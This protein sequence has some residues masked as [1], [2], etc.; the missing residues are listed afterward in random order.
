[1]ENINTTIRKRGAVTGIYLGLAL[2]ILDLLLYLF[3]TKGTESF[4]MIAIVSNMA[5]L[6]LEIAV[7]VFFCN[8]L[9]TKIGGYWSLRQ[10]VTG[11]FIMFVI[12]FAIKFVSYDILYK[13]VI[14]KNVDVNIHTAW[15]NANLKT[16]KQGADP[17]SVKSRQEKID[18]NFVVQKNDGSV[19]AV[20]MNIAITII[21]MFVAALLFAALFKRNPP[22]QVTQ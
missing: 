15:Q 7:T 11:I 14:D 20:I 22:F 10:A 12:A 17:K 2:L 21:M 9:R 4:F 18:A 19:K 6:L 16:L 5:L 3:I 1:M 8:K 13:K